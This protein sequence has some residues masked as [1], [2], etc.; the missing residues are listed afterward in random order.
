VL[1]GREQGTRA[2]PVEGVLDIRLFVPGGTE[3][4]STGLLQR[5]SVP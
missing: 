1:G 3:K 2:D 5:S 4:S